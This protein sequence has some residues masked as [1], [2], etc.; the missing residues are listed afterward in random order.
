MQALAPVV[1]VPQ[2][3]AALI[4]WQVDVCALEKLGTPFFIVT[5]GRTDDLTNE[6]KYD[7]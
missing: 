1:Y 3:D 4:T 2:L 7:A 5:T 6:G